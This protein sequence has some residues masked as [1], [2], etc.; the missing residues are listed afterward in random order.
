V[1]TVAAVSWIGWPFV[2]FRQGAFLIPSAAL[3]PLAAVAW[4]WIARSV[5]KEARQSRE[6]ERIAENSR[7]G[8]EAASRQKI[9]LVVA[10]FCSGIV[11]TMGLAIG[12]YVGAFA[13]AV[14]STP[15]DAGPFHRP[16]ME[17]LVAQVR[18][19][20][21]DGR[22]DFKWAEVS[23]TAMLLTVATQGN[24]S[25]VFAER[26]TDQT[27][28]VVIVIHNE[29]HMGAYGFAYSDVPLQPLHDSLAPED[30]DL[31]QLELPGPLRNSR[32]KMQID[33]HWWEMFDADD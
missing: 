32:P 10:G 5:R 24:D 18:S 6:Q 28:K 30:K 14:V 25:L 8:K 33:S 22:K 26:S 31:L 7:A 1:L 3:G 9:S 12:L 20:K 15:R 21:F 19:Q 4:A 29:G 17:S 13:Y 2:D 16:Q 27:L 11:L 23:G